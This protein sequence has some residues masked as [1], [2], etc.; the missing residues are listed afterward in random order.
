SKDLGEK[1]SELVDAMTQ[2]HLDQD[3]LKKLEE[4]YSSSGGTSEAALRQA[5]RNVSAGINAV[6]KAKRTLLT[7]K[8]PPDEIK[9]IEDEANR[10]IARK[11]KRDPKRE[12]DWAR[13]DIKA[14]ITGV[15]VEK[16][17]LVGHIVDTTTDLFKVADM[18]RL[19]V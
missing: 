16:N 4:L 1:K 15:I 9:A 13:V 12:T 7:W 10:I 8:V 6:N 11:G 17:A 18:S 14:P 19:A 2:L 5:R 3:T